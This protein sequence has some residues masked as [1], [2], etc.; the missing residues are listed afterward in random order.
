[1][2]DQDIIALNTLAYRYAAGVDACDTPLF[3]SVFTPDARMHSYHPGADEPFA[4][5]KG[6]DQIAAVPEAMR[7]M[8]RHTM[9]MMTNHLV[10]IDGYQGTGTVLCTA[11]HL[12]NDGKSA[13]NV[14]IRYEDQY[15]K[16]HGDWKIAD[17]RIRFLW[18]ERHAVTDSGF[19]QHEGE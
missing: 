2:E 10:E 7:G 15:E 5:L 6:H 16:H 14:M 11:R 19:G 3:L 8:F 12:E 9:H 17:R 18:S 1:M 4:D 13:L